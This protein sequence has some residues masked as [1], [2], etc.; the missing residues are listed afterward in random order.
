MRTKIAVI[1]DGSLVASAYHRHTLA[2]GDDY[3]NESDTVRAICGL[4]H[5]AE[6]VAL[7]KGRMELHS[8]S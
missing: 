3:S 8:T 6:A 7:F 4:I 5:T 1:D 2:P